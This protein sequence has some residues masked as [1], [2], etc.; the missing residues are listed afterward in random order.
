MIRH[1]V[2]LLL[3]GFIVTGSAA[4]DVRYYWSDGDRCVIQVH[5]FKLQPVP[6][7]RATGGLEVGE[8]VYAIGN[9]RRLQRS[10]S[11]GLISG[12]R[13]ERQG[14]LIQ[15]TAPISPGSSGGGLFDSR[16]KL[17]GITSLTTVDSQNLNF[18]VSADDFWK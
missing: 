1:W 8:S 12:I 3:S 15:T 5:K 10:L 13:D 4:A 16:G 9:P 18:A 17:L 7:V 2:V 11:Q 6:G 14:R